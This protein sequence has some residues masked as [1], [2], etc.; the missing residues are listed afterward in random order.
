MGQREFT[1][2]TV[3]ITDSIGCIALN[4]PERLNAM[5]DAL[6]NESLE[7]VRWLDGH[8]DLRVVILKGNERAPTCGEARRSADDDQGS[9]QRNHA[10]HGCRDDIIRR[11]RPCALGRSR[12]RRTSRPARI[13]SRDDRQ[14]A[15]KRLSRPYPNSLLLT[16]PR[17]NLTSAAD[18]W[19]I[20]RACM[21]STRISTTLG[22][23]Y[24]YNR[25]DDADPAAENGSGDG[26]GRTV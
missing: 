15:R 3:E 20:N 13:R 17:S 7:A 23:D 5:N 1:T 22:R 25:R 19:E 2:L 12:G 16:N 21:F 14:V 9:H 8:Q 6:M 18:T 10:R 24:E 26:S 4:R 11:Q